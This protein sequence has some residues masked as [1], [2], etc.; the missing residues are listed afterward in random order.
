MRK[1]V[2]MAAMAAT[3]ASAGC[4]QARVQ[5]AGPTI[6]KRFNVGSFDQIEVAGPY[7]VDVRTGG[8]PGV[9]ARG[10]KNLLEHTVVEVK[11]GK[12]VIHPEKSRG[13]FG[14][15]FRT[16]GS[17][18]L[19]VTAPSLRGATVAG[20]GSLTIDKVIGDSFEGTVAGSGGLDVSALQAGS[21]RFAIGGSGDIR[22]GSGQAQTGAYKIAGSGDVD[23]RGLKV[24]TATIAIT[25]SGGVKGQVTGTADVKIVGSGDVTLTGGAKCNV[26]TVG[27]GSV[28]GC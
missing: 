5:D 12:L 21:T 18:K 14:R 2:M 1:A 3:A 4:S 24:A 23:T 10:S 20:S 26:S 27:S 16:N 7:E 19:S 9:T 22:V 6:D 25:G 28:N 8:S 13:W 17:A 15:G 11:G